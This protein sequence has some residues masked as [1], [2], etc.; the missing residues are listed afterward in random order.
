MQDS[1]SYVSS[2]PSRINKGMIRI[3]HWFLISFSE[4]SVKVLFRVIINV[5]KPSKETSDVVA[6]N[7][8][9]RIIKQLKTGRIGT[10][11][12]IP[13]A[14]QLKGIMRYT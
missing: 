7:V 14:I 11:Q 3:V 12:V 10:M 9:H 13:D 5:F 2:H 6:V 8:G 4:G 1:L